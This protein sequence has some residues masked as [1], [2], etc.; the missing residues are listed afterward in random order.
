MRSG[1]K[2]NL[3]T[4]DVKTSRKNQF[5]SNS[6]YGSNDKGRLSNL[7]FRSPLREQ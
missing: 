1:Y 3:A 4:T 5:M 6:P 7:K 2:D